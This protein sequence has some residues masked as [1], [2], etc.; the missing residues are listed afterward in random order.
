MDNTA[1]YFTQNENISHVCKQGTHIIKNFIIK[2]TEHNNSFYFCHLVMQ[3][4]FFIITFFM[5]NLFLH[6][7][8]MKDCHAHDDAPYE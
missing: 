3:T 7:H 6:V 4:C 8:L 2:N 1:I 5:A